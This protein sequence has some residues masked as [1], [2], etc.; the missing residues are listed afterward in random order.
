MSAGT[1]SVEQAVNDLVDAYRDRCL[2]FLRPDFYP[3]TAEE[4]LRV[5]G[6]VERYGDVAAFRR[7]GVLRKCLS[8]RSS[9]PS[10]A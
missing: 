8:R 9:E 4:R 10:A 7:A 6:Y 5:L 2:W 3:A 1:E